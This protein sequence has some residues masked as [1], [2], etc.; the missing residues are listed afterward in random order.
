MRK[1]WEI[2][3]KYKDS[4]NTPVA[5][6]VVYGKSVTLGGNNAQLGDGIGG[7]TNDIQKSKFL[8]QEE[9]MERYIHTVTQ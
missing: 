5:S 8:G 7:S 9:A 4:S 2:A 6:K 1:W 3:T